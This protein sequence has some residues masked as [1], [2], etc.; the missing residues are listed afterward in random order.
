[1]NHQNLIDSLETRRFLSATAVL[2]AGVLSVTGTDGDDRVAIYT[3]FERIADAS[4]DGPQFERNLYVRGVADGPAVFAARE[5]TSIDIDLGA[6]DDGLAIWRVGLSGDLSIDTGAGDDSVFA[7]TVGV[8]GN[9]SADLGEGDDRAFF[10]HVR[11]AGE[12]SFDGGEGDDSF[13]ARRTGLRGDDIVN[14]ETGRG[15]R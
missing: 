10:S 15:S 4:P 5:V 6:G 12:R 13:F 14:V 2:D 7:R 1:M 8:G 11:I 9:F 3:R